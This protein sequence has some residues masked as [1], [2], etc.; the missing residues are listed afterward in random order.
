MLSLLCL[1]L[2]GVTEVGIDPK[3]RFVSFKVTTFSES[4]LLEPLQG[5]APKNSWLGDAFLKDYKIICKM[6][7]TEMK[8]K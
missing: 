3:G 6:K 4:S 1:S 2:E 5:I 8:T 7:M